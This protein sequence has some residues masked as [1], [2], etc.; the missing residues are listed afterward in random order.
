MWSSDLEE[1]KGKNAKLAESLTATA[2]QVFKNLEVIKVTS[3]P[4]GFRQNLLLV[5]TGIPLA[6]YQSDASATAKKFITDNRVEIDL[7]SAQILTDDFAPV[8]KFSAYGL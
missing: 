2:A 7:S 8:E 3:T 6:D 5:A 4:S 1:A